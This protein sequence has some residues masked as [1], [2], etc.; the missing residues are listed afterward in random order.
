MTRDPDNLWPKTLLP[1]KVSNARF[2]AFGYDAHVANLSEIVSKE[3]IEQHAT[4]LLEA[5][6]EHR[7]M[8]KTGDSVS[9]SNQGVSEL[10]SLHE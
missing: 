9:F 5:V 3:R 10:C 8:D 7:E 1:A 4:S 6:A 2:L